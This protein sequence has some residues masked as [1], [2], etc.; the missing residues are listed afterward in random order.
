MSPGRRTYGGPEGVD[1]PPKLKWP[2]S[3]AT[4][5]CGGGRRCQFLAQMLLRNDMLRPTE[6]LQFGK[7]GGV[8]RR[9]RLPFLHKQAV[10]MGSDAVAAIYTDASS[11]RGWGAAF[12]DL[13]IQGNWSK[14]D[15]SEGINWQ[16]LWVLKPA[17][18]SWGDRLAGNLVRARMDN[19]AAA[20][21][22]NFGAGRVSHLTLLARSMKELEAPL[23]CT[24]V[25][26]HF[27]GQRNA[28]ADALSRLTFRAR[29]LDPYPRRGLRPKFR[30]EVVGRCG[31]ID[32]DMLARDDGSNAWA[33]Q[34]RSPANSAFE[35]HLPPGQLWRSPMIDLALTR[36]ISPRKE[37]WSGSHLRLRPL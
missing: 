21:Y 5:C 9:P 11:L 14:L 35:G 19:S 37:D 34:C 32:F 18:E 2:S 13:Y 22:A 20:A 6:K 27:A 8:V 31:A 24:A 10:H 15:R 4:A 33:P 7:D 3:Y 29:G 12:G 25:A 28:V 23:G 30:Q 17:L 16:E 1:H 36:M 26:L